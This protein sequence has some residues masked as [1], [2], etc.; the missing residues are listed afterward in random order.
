MRDVCGMKNRDELFRGLAVGIGAGAAGAAGA[1]LIK[2]GAPQESVLSLLGALIG[3]AATV[4]GAAWL[5]DRNAKLEENAERQLLT[6][7]ILAIRHLAKSALDLAAADGGS[8]SDEFRHSLRALD[9]PLRE[10][11]SICVEALDH[12]RRLTFRQ[13]MRLRQMEA[14]SQRAWSFYHD[15]FLLDDDLHPMDERTWP[16]MLE[17]I[18]KSADLALASLRT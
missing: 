15:C 18:V 16:G 8:W 4:A 14:A 6:E 9:P 11:H 17:D 7:E 1:C 3:A 2:F 5:S 12:G 10:I 13:R